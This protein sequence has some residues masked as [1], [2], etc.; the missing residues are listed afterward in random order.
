M[1]IIS[2]TA[3]SGCKE[4]GE[5]PS[6]IRRLE[7]FLIYPGQ[8]LEGRRGLG[9]SMCFGCIALQ[10]MAGLVGFA[11]PDGHVVR[12]AVLSACAGAISGCPREA[13]RVPRR[14]SVMCMLRI[15]SSRYGVMQVGQEMVRREE[16]C[17]RRNS[18]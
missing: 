2:T 1:D 13:S 16:K 9:R 6:L 17:P 4:H 12:D 10:V 18:H 7:R 3:F 11:R 5:L 15:G 14:A 8:A